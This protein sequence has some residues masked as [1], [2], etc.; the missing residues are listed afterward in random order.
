MR[1][2]GKILWSQTCHR[3]QYNTAHAH[4]ML[5]NKVTNTHMEYENTHCFSTATMV[6]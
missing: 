6:K 2:Y 3:C 1:Q 5:G 4:C